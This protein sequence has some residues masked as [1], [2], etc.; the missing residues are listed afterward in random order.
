LEKICT[1]IGPMWKGE[2]RES[3]TSGSPHLVL[4]ADGG[5]DAAVAYGIQPDFVIGDFDSMPVS[6]LAQIPFRQL[7]WHKDDTDMRLCLEEGRSRGYRVFQIYGGLGGRLDHTLANI[8]CLA[9]CADKGEEAWL[10]DSR[11][12]LTVLLPG[13]YT[14]PGRA[15]Q[16]LSIFAMT[17]RVEHVELTGTE[18][19]LHGTDL[20]QTYPLGVS[21][22]MRAE[23]V[24]LAFSSGRLILV[25]CDKEG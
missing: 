11:H 19:E 21:N 5:Y 4:C 15:E 9:E 20:V 25:F 17:E 23:R 24:H 22:Q 13:E 3:M 14:F 2:R 12:A 8:Q 6:H 18:W 7:S 10:F 16:Y 1:I